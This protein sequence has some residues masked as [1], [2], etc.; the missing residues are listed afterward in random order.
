MR[1]L[2]SVR[3]VAA[4]LLFAMLLSACLV[5]PVANV[6]AGDEGPTPP[7][8]DPDTTSGGP[9]GVISDPGLP[10]LELVLITVTVL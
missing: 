1:R 10:V 5:L 7:V 9:N 3:L 8:I 2:L 6:R 4:M